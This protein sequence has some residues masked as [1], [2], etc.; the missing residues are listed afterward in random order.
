VKR[1]YIMRGLPGSGKS[2][3]ARQLRG[4]GGLVASTDDYWQ[5]GCR[6]E[7][8]AS[9]IMDAHDWNQ[10]RFRA[11]V[12]AEVPIIVV[13]NTNIMERHWR[14]YADFARANGYTVEFVEVDSG[15][16]DEE[17]AARNTHRVPLDVIQRMRANWE[18]LP[19]EEARKE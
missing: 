16:S 1:C 13:D 18:P 7:Y 2:T 8:D 15:L 12:R 4:S 11:A 10:A 9:R 5:H 17:L 14:P 6:Y 3:I 19:G